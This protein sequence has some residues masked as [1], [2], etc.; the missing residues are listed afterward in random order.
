MGLG[1]SSAIAAVLVLALYI[2]SDD[3]QVLYSSPEFLWLM[4]PIVLYWQLRMVMVTHRGHMTDDPI[5]FAATDRT[6]QITIVLA[7]LLIPVAT[8][9]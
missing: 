9:L 6:S 1:L 8:F 2:A 7:M 4:C 3:V 5:V